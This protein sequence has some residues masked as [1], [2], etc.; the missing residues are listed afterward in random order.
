MKAAA[1]I[2]DCD[3]I[4]SAALILRKHP[5]TTI[6]F[7]T[8]ESIVHSTEDY[9]IVVD[10]PKSPNAKVN[11]DHHISNLENLRAKG[12]LGKNDIIDPDAPSAASVLIKY[13][14]LENDPIAKELVEM[15]NIA[16][17]GG[18]SDETIIL[19]KLIKS[20]QNDVDFLRYL[21]KVLSEKGKKFLEDEKIKKKWETLSKTYEKY[22]KFI[23]TLADNLPSADFII[24][25]E[26]EVLSYYVAK[27]LAYEMFKRNKAKVVALIYDSP[28]IDSEGKIS[29]RVAKDFDFDSRKVAVKFDGGG[30]VKAAGGRFKKGENVVEKMI[31]ELSKYSNSGEV[32]VVILKNSNYINILHDTN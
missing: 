12:A 17:T 9:D 32:L 1:H 26:R 27:D 30:H 24:F 5:N 4:I 29:L 23:T 21:A 20:N 19:D 7:H 13:L 31:Y 16:D 11:I 8:T 22:Q 6:D 15:A 14:G 25:D 28:Y 18:V 3:G 2:A 10:L